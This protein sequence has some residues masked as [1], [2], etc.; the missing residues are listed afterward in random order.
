MNERP[1]LGVSACIFRAGAVLLVERARAPF[2]GL[3]SLPGGKVEFGETL[4]DAIAREV[5]E[6]TGLRIDRFAFACLHEA[7]EPGVH[8][9]I[10]VHRAAEALAPSVEPIAGDDAGQVRFV[11]IGALHEMAKAGQLTR[12][13]R[14]VVESAYRDH[15]LCL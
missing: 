15:L 1:T 7:I 3:L 2:A 11:E 8:V 12:G 5:V 9:V 10:A 6:E 4:A 13:L 14:D